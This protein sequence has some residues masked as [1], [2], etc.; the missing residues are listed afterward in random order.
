LPSPSLF[1]EQIVH[2][3]ELPEIV[4]FDE[5]AGHERPAGRRAKNR[6]K[7]IRGPG[8]VL[9]R[10]LVSPK[11]ERQLEAVQLVLRNIAVRIELIL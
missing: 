2:K 9:H 5:F 8:T 7:V 4:R 11:C 1:E 3:A 6:S 10:E